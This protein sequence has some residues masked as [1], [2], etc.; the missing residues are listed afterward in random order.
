MQVRLRP[1][2]FGT[3]VTYLDE[4]HAEGDCARHGRLRGWFEGKLKHWAHS[5]R[6]SRGGLARRMRGL[7]EWLERRKYHDEA[8]LARLRHAGSLEVHHPA[9]LSEDDARL[10]WETYLSQRRRRHLSWFLANAVVSPLTLLLAPLPGPNLVGYWFAYRS[11]HHLLIL[12]GLRKVRAG[13]FPTRFHPEGHSHTKGDGGSPEPP[14]GRHD[15]NGSVTP[16]DPGRV[17]D[18]NL[19]G[20]AVPSSGESLGAR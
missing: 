6:E 8:D 14:G 17:Y 13:T 10:L 11:V 1:K 3:E 18:E 20:A 16:T 2:D 15:S 5:W 4:P 12:A 7:W 9:G 19:L